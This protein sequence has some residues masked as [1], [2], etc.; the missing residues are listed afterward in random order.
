MIVKSKYFNLIPK[1]SEFVKMDDHRYNV[2]SVQNDEGK[3]VGK[4]DIINMEGAFMIDSKDGV[5]RIGPSIK[6]RL[7]RV[8][9]DQDEHMILDQLHKDLAYKR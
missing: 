6:E 5:M 3:E 1:D 9:Y 8:Y 7:K 4:H 2:I